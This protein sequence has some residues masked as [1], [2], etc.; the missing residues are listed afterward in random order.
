MSFLFTISCV[1][2]KKPVFYVERNNSIYSKEQRQVYNKG[3]LT[4]IF[5]ANINI[6]PNRFV[7]LKKEVLILGKGFKTLDPVVRNRLRP[8][9]M[10]SVSLYTLLLL[11]W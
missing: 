9:Q 8:D 5:E 1:N 3:D 6:W 2:G 7:E 10:L 11:S 4:S